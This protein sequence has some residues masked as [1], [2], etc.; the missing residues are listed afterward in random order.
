MLNDLLIA[1][2]ARQH[3]SYTWAEEAVAWAVGEIVAGRDTPEI[4]V[5]AGMSPPFDGWEIKEQLDKAQAEA[6]IVPP[7]KAAC[8]RLYARPVA[9][10]LLDGTISIPDACHALS[11]FYNR[12]DADEYYN[13][14]SLNEAWDLL[15]YS[16][17]AY[18]PSMEPDAL[19]QDARMEARKLL[20]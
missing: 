20:S 11:E 10:A 8:L 13:W 1:A 19:N 3:L 6:G 14:Y 4:C 2:L 7:D 16:G 15:V 5:L 17:V 12:A 18:Y 9:Q